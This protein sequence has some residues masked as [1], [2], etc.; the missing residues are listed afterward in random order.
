MKILEPTVNRKILRLRSSKII[1]RQDI[2]LRSRVVSA[3]GIAFS[4]SRKNKW[5]GQQEPGPPISL[6]KAPVPHNA[7]ESVYYAKVCVPTPQSQY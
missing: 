1:F 2:A 7:T 3:N 5:E 6:K 4:H